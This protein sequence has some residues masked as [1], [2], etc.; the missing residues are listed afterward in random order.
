MTKFRR[1]YSIIMQLQPYNPDTSTIIPPEVKQ[2]DYRKWCSWSRGRPPEIEIIHQ[3]ATLHFFTTVHIYDGVNG[4]SIQWFIE[5]QAFLRSY[6]LAPL[7]LL[8]SPI[9]KMSLFLSLPVCRGGGVSQE[10][11]HSNAR[12]PSPLQIIQYS[13]GIGIGGWIYKIVINCISKAIA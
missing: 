2:S 12:K 13:R 4:G 11:N 9:S 1:P 10:P 7:P 5:D 6:D 8:P 3:H